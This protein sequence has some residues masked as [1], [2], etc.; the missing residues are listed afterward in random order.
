MLKPSVGYLSHFLKGGEL[1]ISNDYLNLLA[2][3]E[4]LEGGIYQDHVKDLQ[5]AV[6]KI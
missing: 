1:G 3:T 4:V 2:Q 6:I 5:K